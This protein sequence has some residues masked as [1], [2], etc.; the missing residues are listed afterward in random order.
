MRKVTTK[1]IFSTSI[2]LRSISS[3]IY[4]HYIAMLKLVG[5]FFKDLDCTGGTG[6]KYARLGMCYD[7]LSAATYKQTGII[8]VVY[9]I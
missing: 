9:Y 8:M 5:L 4:S 1:E 7:F 3:N 6:V 2:T